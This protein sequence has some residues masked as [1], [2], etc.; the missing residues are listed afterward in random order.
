MPLKIG[1]I[2]VDSHNFPNLPLMKLSA[3]HKS[4]GDNVEMCI[5]IEQ[6]DIIYKS[7]IFT[8]TPDVMYSYK[9]DVI[10]EGGTGYDVPKE[11]HAGIESPT[12]MLDLP[13]E[14]E[15]IMPHYSLY[16]KHSEAYGFLTRGCYR[17]CGFCVVSKKEGRCSRKVANLSDFYTGQKI[18][19]LLDPNLLA[20][21]DHENLLIQLADSKAWVDLTQGLDVRLLNKDIIGL[22]NNIKTKII[23]F[24]WDNPTENLIPQFELFDK[25]SKLKHYTK[26]SVYV[27]TNY[28][29]THEQDLER[30]YRLKE[31]G[32]NPFI[33]IYDK[34][35]APLITKHLQRWVNNR[36]IFR[37]CENFED[38]TCETKK[39]SKGAKIIK[40]NENKEVVND[41]MQGQLSYDEV[42]PKLTLVIYTIYGKST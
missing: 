28:N 10:F 20:C 16:P 11:Y 14:I 23:H 4:K 36:R 27:L 32:Y 30:V 41:P 42:P 19:K 18:I 38:Y 26:R 37:S 35:N 15:N 39:I 12:K 24:A 13:K 33:M 22:L 25:Y 29:S 8:H 31:L 17:D 9:A 1:L 2:D 6:Y 5:P 21:S 7:K 3:Y 34:E 40:Q